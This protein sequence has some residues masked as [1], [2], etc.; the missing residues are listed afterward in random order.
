MDHKTGLQIV[1]E[2]NGKESKTVFKRIST[3]GKT[4]LVQCEPLTGR[5]HQIRVHLQYLGYP[6]ANDPLYNC[7]SFGPNIGK[8]GD[9]G[10]GTLQDVSWLII[11]LGF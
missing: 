10:E 11:K 7:D 2:K 6:I 4:S 9:Y 5:T 8:G 1:D 3:D